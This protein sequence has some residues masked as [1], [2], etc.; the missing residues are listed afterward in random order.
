VS[1]LPPWLLTVLGAIIGA[2]LF[3]AGMLTGGAIFWSPR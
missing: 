2:V 3:G 1:D